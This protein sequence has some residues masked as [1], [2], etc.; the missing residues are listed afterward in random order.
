MSTRSLEDLIV[1]AG[2]AENLLIHWGEAGGG[3][4]RFVTPATDL[5]SVR[6]VVSP[7]P[8]SSVAREHYR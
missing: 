5:Y 2:N 6:G 3:Y 8:F 7:A 1:E 4:G